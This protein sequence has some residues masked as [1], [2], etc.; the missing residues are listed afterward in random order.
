MTAEL[1]AILI[2]FQVWIVVLLFT[3]LVWNRVGRQWRERRERERTEAVAEALAGWGRDETGDQELL[4][5]MDRANVR[6]AWEAFESEFRD[7][8]EE[9]RY[10][11]RELIRASRWFP[12][13]ERSLKSLLW[14]RRVDGIQM[15]SHLGK[16]EDAPVLE[17]RLSDR[18]P[19]V[20]MAAV[21]TARR[22][23]LPE[24][25]DPLLA[26][27]IE[28]PSTRRKAYLDALLAYGDELVP[29]VRNRL[30]SSEDTA[31][32]LTLLELA[33][34][35]PERSRRAGELVQLIVPFTTDERSEVRIRAVSALA[36]YEAAQV[37]PALHSALRDEAWPVRAKAA[38]ALGILGAVESREEL[39]GVL[40]D[41]HWWVRLRA[42]ISLRQLGEV[43]E[44]VLRDVGAAE[45]PFAHDMSRY[46]L[47]L[48][49]RALLTY[50]V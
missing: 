26:R 50:E 18:Q 42:G 36:S 13:V 21:F 12:R 48:D 15:L 11:V 49:D 8:D 23:I 35:L 2:S 37:V 19:M 17:D 38:G 25:I 29:V 5:A 10:R 22:L 14:W 31:E 40:S 6:A 32:L 39:R 7:L 43:G 46:V 1:L 34:D 4:E 44:R 41:A 45:D 16:R 20:R 33:E 3:F 24:L 27:A 9:A 30:R 28:A 47:R